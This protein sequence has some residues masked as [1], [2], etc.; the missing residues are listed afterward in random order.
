MYCGARLQKYVPRKYLKLILGLIITF[1]ALSY[2]LQ[3]FKS[4]SP[5][6]RWLK[7]ISASS[8]GAVDV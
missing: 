7:E 5:P 2:V 4:Q 3:Y 1:L 8:L 6:V